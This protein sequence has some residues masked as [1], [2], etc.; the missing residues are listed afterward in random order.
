MS[1]LFISVMYV[2]VSKLFGLAKKGLLKIAKKER[3]LCNVIIL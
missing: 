1:P 3:F 2:C